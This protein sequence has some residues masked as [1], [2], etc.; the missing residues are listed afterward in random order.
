[1]FDAVVLLVHLGLL[2]HASVRLLGCS[3]PQ[4]ADNYLKHVHYKH[5]YKFLERRGFAFENTENRMTKCK[6][7][8]TLVSPPQITGCYSKSEVKR[9]L[10]EANV[11]VDNFVR[12]LRKH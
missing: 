1:M 4:M 9:V 12:W 3:L 7:G 2:C 5:L 6:Q 8:A 10:K 11:D